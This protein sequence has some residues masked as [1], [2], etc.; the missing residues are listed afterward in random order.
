[1]SD[2]AG[3]LLTDLRGGVLHVVFNR[4]EKKNALTLAMYEAA[5]AAFAR[6]ASDAAVRAVLIAGEGGSF[7][8]G[9]DLQ[10]FLS[11]PPRGEEAPVLQFLRHLATLDKPLIAAAQGFAVG[12]GTTLLMHCDLVY[13]ADDAQFVLPFV[14]LGLCPEAASSL[15]LPQIAG[16]QRAAEK[17]LLG[18]PFGAAEA[19]QMGLVNRVLPVDELRGFAVMQAEKFARLPAS[20]VRATKRLLKG[21]G[22][23]GPQAVLARM[24]AEEQLFQALLGAPAAREAMTAFLQKRKPDFSAI[25]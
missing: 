24:R 7:T 6:A 22:D 1:M 10:D 25:E 8:A 17:L 15:L 18:E 16:Y 9:N 21:L 4:P 5:N 2:A 14:H 12:V 23:Q 11:S 20:S 13:A 3:A 19:L